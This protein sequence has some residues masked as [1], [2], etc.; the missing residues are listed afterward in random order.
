MT[1]SLPLALLALGALGAGLIA[2][3]VARMAPRLGFLGWALVLFFVPVWVGVTVGPFW[4]AISLTTALLVATNWSAV[5]LSTADLF[6]A[7]FVMLAGVGYGVGSVSLSALVIALTEWVM[8]YVWGR[9]ALARMSTDWVTVVIGSVAV[10]AAALVVLEF[11]VGINPFVLI[12]GS[13]E[14]YTT[15]SPRQIRGGVI[16]AEGAFGHSIALG[17]SM[18]ISVAFVIGTRWPLIP[19]LLATGLVGLA[20]ILT[21]SRAG[22]I[23]FVFTLALA[24]VFLPGLTRRFRAVIVATAV[25][26]AGVVMTQLGAVFDAADSDLEVSGGYRTDLLVLLERVHVI[27]NAG[28][29]SSLIVG[30][31]YLG[32]FARSVDNALLVFLLRFGWIPTV[33]LVAPIVC[34]VATAVRRQTRSPASLAVVGQ[35]PSLVVVAL[36]TQYGMLLW[37]CVGLALTWAQLLRTVESA[38]PFVEASA[39]GQGPAL[40]PLGSGSE[41][42]HWSSRK[43]PPG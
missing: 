33:L 24:T 15:W 20:T 8:P 7:G 34:A 26:I 23:T 30:D 19:K 4:A 21:F 2:G 6:M 29:W 5:P 12:P 37:F 3:L 43:S 28:D 14:A 25:A 40:Q 10:L 36:I 18:A 1:T 31:N 11:T 22:I 38:P 13:G 9:V 27:G 32:Y 17:G 39:G 41:V 35:L 16:R 42:G